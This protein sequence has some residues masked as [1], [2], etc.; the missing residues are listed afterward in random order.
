MVS[1]SGVTRRSAWVVVQHLVHVIRVDAA[2]V[3]LN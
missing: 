1:P 2:V 3:A